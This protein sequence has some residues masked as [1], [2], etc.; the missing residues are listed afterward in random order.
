MDSS[1][2]LA[3]ATMARINRQLGDLVTMKSGSAEFAELQVE[4]E[5]SKRECQELRRKLDERDHL[6]MRLQNDKDAADQHLQ[7][8]VTVIGRN[9]VELETLRHQN[10]SMTSTTQCEEFEKFA[11]NT[12]DDL[13]SEIFA[14]KNALKRAENGGKAEKNGK[15]EAELRNEI[16]HLEIDLANAKK[17]I[18]G[19][20]SY[21]GKL[22]REVAELLEEKHGKGGFARAAE[23][24]KSPK[25]DDLPPR[26]VNGFKSDNGSKAKP[27]NKAAKSGET[28]SPPKT[29]YWRAYGYQTRDGVKAADNYPRRG[30][31]DFKD[32]PRFR[33]LEIVSDDDSD[34]WRAVSVPTKNT[35]SA[36]NELSFA[37]LVAEQKKKLADNSARGGD[38]WLYGTGFGCTPR[39]TA[40]GRQYPKD[41]YDDVLICK[42]GMKD[43][44]RAAKPV[45]KGRDEPSTSAQKSDSDSDDSDCDW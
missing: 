19:K 42:H 23:M 9:E 24:T 36:T 4:L 26:S 14:L 44:G 6:I 8:A 3:A 2:D 1:A 33:D 45:R 25:P 13:Q 31:A 29:G 41:D 5:V 7:V 37:R 12:I 34:M 11:N 17:R 32:G 40:W 18:Q 20:D 43:A 35:V 10:P 22:K 16:Q 28:S 21:I 15:K 27:K 38:G 30:F 39:G